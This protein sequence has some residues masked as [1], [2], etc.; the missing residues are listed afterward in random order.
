[1]FHGC[2]VSVQDDGRVLHGWRWGLHNSMTALNAPEQ[3][4]ENGSNGKLFDIYI[5]S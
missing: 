5:L 1:M 4:T 3:D 2:R